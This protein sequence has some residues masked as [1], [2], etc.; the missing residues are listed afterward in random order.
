MD[1]TETNIPI[2]HLPKIIVNIPVKYAIDVSPSLKARTLSSIDLA[3][4]T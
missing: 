1:N 2:S 3:L 4:I